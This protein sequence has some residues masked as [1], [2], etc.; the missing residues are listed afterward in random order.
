MWLTLAVHLFERN[1]DLAEVPATAADLADAYVREI[2]EKQD[3]YPAERVLGAL[4]RVALQ[5]GWSKKF[6]ASRLRLRTNSK[7]LPWNWLVPL[8]STTFT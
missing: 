4:R 8:L 3:A 2:V 1:G 5:S 6:L 7:P